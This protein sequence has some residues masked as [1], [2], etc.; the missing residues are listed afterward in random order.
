MVFSSDG[1]KM[2][3]KE[4]KSNEQN[5]KQNERHNDEENLLNEVSS[6][7]CMIARYCEIFIKYN[8]DDD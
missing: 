3:K 2:L 6:I 5:N 1:E 8:N 4:K 7:G